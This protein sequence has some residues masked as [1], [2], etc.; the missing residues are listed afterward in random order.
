MTVYKDGNGEL[1]LFNSFQLTEDGWKE[2]DS[3][4]K[5]KNVVRIGAF[6][7]GEDAILLNRYKDA[8]YWILEGMECA[9][10]LDCSHTIMKN[11]NVPIK[12]MK[13][14]SPPN[15]E[16]PEAAVLLPCEDGV[17]VTCD[18]VQNQASLGGEYNS[19]FMRLFMYFGGFVGE[20]R[21][22]PGWLDACYKHFGKSPEENMLNFFK[23]TLKSL[24]FD[25]LMPG[26]G[27]PIVGNAKQKVFAQ[28][29]VQ[30]G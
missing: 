26:H 6:H 12:G 24:D 4:G 22:G 8:K 25:I 2:L 17:L 21:V 13:L 10:G 11:S 14:F 9:L 15:A 18:M 27:L 19:Y 30:F 23:D 28:A 29:K 7:G 1:T 16:F 20:G 5:V 3:L